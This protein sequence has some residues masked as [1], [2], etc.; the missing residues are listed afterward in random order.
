[1]RYVLIAVVAV[2]CM[3]S[4]LHAADRRPPV[5]PAEVPASIPWAQTETLPLWVSAA[6]AIDGKGDLRPEKLSADRRARFE[7]NRLAN[8]T[9]ECKQFIGRPPETYR[10]TATIDDLVGNALTIVS[11]DVV[12]AEQG[13]YAGEAGTLL[14]LK[15]TERLKTFGRT[16]IR[17]RAFVFI[18]EA[19]ISTQRG[20]ICASTFSQTPTPQVGDRIMVFG[21]FDPVDREGLVLPADLRQQVIVER[22]DGLHFPIAAKADVANLRELTDVIRAHPRLHEVAAGAQP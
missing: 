22:G 3:T 5:P 10:S 9:G 7:K 15:V 12:A 18:A 8:A 4:V 17:D 1:V 21:Y 16:G 19:R 13:F 20:T 14:A 11:G 2:S 6:E